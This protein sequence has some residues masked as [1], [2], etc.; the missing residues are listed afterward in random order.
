MGA[1]RFS[2]SDF[3]TNRAP[4]QTSWA[5]VAF[6]GWSSHLARLVEERSGHLVEGLTGGL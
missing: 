6:P 5:A 2:V 1:G 4:E 3:V